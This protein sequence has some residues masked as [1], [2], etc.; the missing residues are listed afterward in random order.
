M[1]P[2]QHI[3]GHTFGMRLEIGQLMQQA[4]PIFL[5][6]AHADDAAATNGD[7][8]APDGLDGA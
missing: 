2:D 5:G 6:F 4:D 1:H 7:A 3:D 8:R